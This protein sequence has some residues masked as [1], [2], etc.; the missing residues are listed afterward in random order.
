VAEDRGQ[1]LE[2]RVCPAP[3]IQADR[4]LLFEALANLIANALKFT[5]ENGRVTL[6][7]S[8]AAEGPRLEVADTGP[9]IAADERESVLQRFYRS[10]RDERT[11][12]SGLGLSIVAA[13]ARLHEFRL[14]LA[15]AEPGL[16]VAMDCWPAAPKY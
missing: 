7:L 5:P 11:P 14:T 2:L 4:E 3:P 12:G 8:A 10:R 6:T 13:V 1:I 15:D 9:G 16:R